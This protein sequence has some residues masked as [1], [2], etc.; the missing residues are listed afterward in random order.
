[1][2]CGKFEYD[3]ATGEFNVPGA[4]LRH[5]PK[6]I[7]NILLLVVHPWVWWWNNEKK[8]WK[9]HNFCRV[10]LWLIIGFLLLKAYKL[11]LFAFLWAAGHAYV[12]LVWTW[13]F[14]WA[15]VVWL[16]DFIC[17]CCRCFA[18]C[19]QQ[20]WNWFWTLGDDILK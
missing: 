20:G 5:I 3:D 12:W 7:S 17:E 6:F 14:L 8:H 15:V 19:L 2:R 18:P 10:I 9:Q 4:R 11:G 16:W 1:M 13:R